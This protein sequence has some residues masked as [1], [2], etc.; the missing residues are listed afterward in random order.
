MRKQN[1][2]FQL[3][4]VKFMYKFKNHMLPYC[5]YIYYDKINSMH[6]YLT[7]YSTDGNFFLHSVTNQAGKYIGAKLWSNA[8]KDI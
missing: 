7:R 4:V 6:Q 1:N 2:L 5:F 3:E 8:P